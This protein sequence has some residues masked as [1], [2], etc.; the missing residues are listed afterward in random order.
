MSS[1]SA[2][3]RMI[4]AAR[5]AS[6]VVARLRALFRKAEPEKVQLDINDVINEVVLLV[7]REVLSHRVWL[8]L[9]LAA[10][11]PRCSGIV[12]SYSR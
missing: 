5:R 12:F 1:R 10:A 3:E 9:D 2:V 6:E 4:G 7:Q 8:R 11:L